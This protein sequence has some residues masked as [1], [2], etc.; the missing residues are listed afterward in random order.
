MPATS[1]FR[2][3]ALA[4][5]LSLFVHSAL[6]QGAAEHQYT[7]A[8]QGVQGG[9]QEKQLIET[10]IGFDPEARVALDRENDLMAVWSRQ[11]L[12]VVAMQQVIAQWGITIT[13]R[14]L[15]DRD[16]AIHTAE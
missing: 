16:G 10:V 7:F 5:F 1:L 8:L 2:T 11:E 3:S 9:M 13:V 15:K 4:L 6:A 14:D 12:D